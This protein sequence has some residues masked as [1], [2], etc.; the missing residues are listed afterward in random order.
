M[1][2]NAHNG[3]IQIFNY[4]YK[5]L[6]FFFKLGHRTSVPGLNNSIFGNAPFSSSPQ[7]PV[8]S[9]GINP[10]FPVQQQTNMF[11][12][13]Q[14]PSQFSPTS[15]PFIQPQQQQQP[16]G[17]SKINYKSKKKFLLIFFIRYIKFF[18]YATN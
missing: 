1:F 11:P 9:T 12:T 8:T 15:N 2:G 6:L 17:A 10:K 18:W 3:G 16:F 4:N 5:I 14:F 7:V 13:Q